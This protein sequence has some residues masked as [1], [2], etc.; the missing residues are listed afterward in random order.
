MRLHS[1]A[2]V[3]LS[4]LASDE[5]ERSVGRPAGRSANSVC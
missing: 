3:L 5:G 2:V 4:I 1:I